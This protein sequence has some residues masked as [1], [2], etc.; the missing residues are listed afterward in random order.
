MKNN[1]ISI[2]GCGWLG[3]PLAESF[4]KLGFQVNGSTTS[5]SKIEVLKSKGIAP[6][7]LNFTPDI[8]DKNALSE[9]LNADI[10]IINIPPGTRTRSAT[11]HIE[12]VDALIPFIE[13]SPL[14]TLLYVSSTSVYP[15]LNRL[16]KEEE[17][18]RP[19]EAD[20]KTLATAEYKLQQLSTIKTT[21]LRCGGLT[22]YDRLLIRHFAGK[23]N[24]TIGD[25]PV[26]L[27]HRDDVIGIVHKLYRQEKW[28]EVYNAC[29]PL[30]PLKKDFYTYLAKQYH[31]EAPEFINTEN[32]SFKI[33]DTQKLTQELAY[34]FLYPD[35]M[36]YSYNSF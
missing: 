10:L 36:N 8:S 23:K 20:N 32:Q 1:K 30:H 27:I 34:S 4:V 26:N 2:L 29:S 21:V 15:N 17:V 6:F 14:K 28:G 25:E 12:Q 31:F 35:P 33:I 22:G 13:K 9:F 7:L 5:E 3:L 16:V 19:E 11:F 24:L 18:Q